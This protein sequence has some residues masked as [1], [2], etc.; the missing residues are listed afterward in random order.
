[1]Q[2]KVKSGRN[3]GKLGQRESFFLLAR[4]S[5]LVPHDFAAHPCSRSF[6]TQKES[7]ETVLSLAKMYVRE[8]L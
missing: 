8:F 2:I 1:M 3:W 4:A 6:V 5:A 7:E